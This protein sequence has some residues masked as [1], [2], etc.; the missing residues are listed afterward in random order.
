M[1][2]TREMILEHTPCGE[3]LDWFDLNFPTGSGEYQAILDRTVEDGHSE[4]GHWLLDEIGQTRDHVELDTL[5]GDRI[6]C[7]SLTLRSG[8]C[9]NLRVA[10]DLDVGLSLNVGKHLNVGGSMNVGK[11]LDVGWSMNVGDSLTVG[12]SLDVGWRLTVGCSLDVG[13][14]LTVGWSLDVGGSLTV[15]D[16]LTVGGSLT[17]GQYLT[18]GWYLNVGGSL[19]TDIAYPFLVGTKI[20]MVDWPTSGYLKAATKPASMLS[21]HFIERIK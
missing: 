9:R 10:G 2:I 21:G 18:V 19:T 17:V 20:K 13:G 5:D 3:G 4:Y 16:S 15:G 6:F 1:L 11:H 7:G 14:Y 8:K 12:W